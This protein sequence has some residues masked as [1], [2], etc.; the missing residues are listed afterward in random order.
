MK[1]WRLRFPEGMQ[2]SDP[3]LD[4]CLGSRDI[5]E[6]RGLPGEVISGEAGIFSPSRWKC[7]ADGLG[8]R[9]RPSTPLTVRTCSMSLSGVE[10]R[11]PSLLSGEHDPSADGSRKGS[12]SK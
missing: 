8:S 6:K 4:I 9:M 1:R 3:R 5:C 2:W 7:A 11:T 10:G 12:D